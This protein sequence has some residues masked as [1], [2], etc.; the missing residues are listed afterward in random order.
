MV[1][2]PEE[3]LKLNQIDREALAKS[4][5]IIDNKLRNSFKGD[6]ISYRIDMRDSARRD[7]V[8]IELAR[9]YTEAG[10]TFTVQSSTDVNVLI[11]MAS[12]EKINVSKVLQA[13]STSEAAKSVASDE[14]PRVN[15][16]NRERL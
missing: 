12:K 16:R 3:C 6:P 13:N 1:V 5:L 14:T 11:S 9:L 7:L 10:W 15:Q 4:T 2:T 8:L